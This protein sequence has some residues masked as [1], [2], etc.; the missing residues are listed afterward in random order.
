MSL[1]AVIEELKDAVLALK[2]EIEENN[3]RLADLELKPKRK[4]RKK[5]EPEVESEEKQDQ[6][7]VF[8]EH[9]ENR[10]ALVEAIASDA[11][12]GKMSLMDKVKQAQDEAVE[13]FQER[14][15]EEK[16]NE[17]PEKK[18]TL[19]DV[20][21]ETRKTHAYIMKDAVGKCEAGTETK[22]TQKIIKAEIML[23]DKAKTLA[24]IDPKHY[25]EFVKN[26]KALREE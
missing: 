20:Q 11:E 9:K 4:S 23:F 7:D 2:D 16:Q 12:A 25:E 14:L 8:E 19:E 22:Y 24:D 5:K 3:N 6:K 17:K 21:T 13:T 15:K 18:L 26:L 10:K 1:E